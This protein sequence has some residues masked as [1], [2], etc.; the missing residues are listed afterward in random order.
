MSGVLYILVNTISHLKARFAQTLLGFRNSSV[1]FR[2]CFWI[3]L[4]FSHG[5]A[6]ILLKHNFPILSLK[7]VMFSTLEIRRRLRRWSAL[8]NV[9]SVCHSQLLELLEP[10][11][12]G[13]WLRRVEIT[14]E[15][16]ASS[17]YQKLIAGL[18]VL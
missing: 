11:T 8:A 17:P 4:Y 12:I 6:L 15:S 14:I 5:L 13:P 10:L 9:N 1:I 7:F 3:C 2:Y 16:K 18:S